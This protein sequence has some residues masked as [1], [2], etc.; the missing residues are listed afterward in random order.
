[1]RL[2]AAAPAIQGFVEAVGP[3]GIHGWAWLPD[4]PEARLRIELR[5]DGDLLDATVADRARP[6]L[7]RNGIGDG[8]H[9]FVL[10]M[11]DRDATALSICAVTADG[12]THPLPTAL[13]AP[14]RDETRRLVEQ[15]VA[16]QRVLHR[17][18]QALLLAGKERAPAEAAL[19][20]IAA[21][22]AALDA[23]AAEL[24][25]FVA[26][27]DQRLAVLDEARPAPPAGRGN[28]PLVAAL[29]L[30]GLGLAGL[31]VTLGG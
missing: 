29:G 27:L 14:P 2:A 11:P 25:L 28:L 10:A 22:Q 4:V 24:E 16:S 17:N 8:G 21:M 6:D 15:I 12:V 26:R 3:G 19:E 1:M 23:R 7:A 13:A 5:A 20:R 31:A 18:L 9:A 30:F